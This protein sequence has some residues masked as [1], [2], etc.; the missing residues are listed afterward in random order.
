[1]TELSARVFIPRAL[2]RLGRLAVALVWL[3][4]GLWLKVIR[5]DPR[6]TAVAASALGLEEGPARMALEVIGLAET[7]LA[8]WV[9]AGGRARLGALAQTCFLV[10]MNAGGLLGAREHIPDPGGMVTWN[11]AF[12]VLV[13]IIAEARLACPA[14][15]SP[16]MRRE[17]HE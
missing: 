9:L 13:W 4:Q 14:T 8:L 10:A 6:H 7:A 5:P 12:L 17:G 1:M 15:P 2:V 3:W 16:D 11:A